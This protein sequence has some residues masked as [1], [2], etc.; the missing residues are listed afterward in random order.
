MQFITEDKYSNLSIIEPDMIFAYVYDLTLGPGTYI[1]FD[2]LEG[3]TYDF[4]GQ[5][6]TGVDYKPMTTIIAL[7]STPF[8]LEQ[9]DEIQAYI[10][11]NNS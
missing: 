11:A 8:T 3:Y 4:Q 10:E 2:P 5:H 6:Q 1:G 9:L 7:Q